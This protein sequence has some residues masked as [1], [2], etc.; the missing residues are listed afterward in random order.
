[1][2]TYTEAGKAYMEGLAKMVRK[3]LESPPGTCC[4]C[5]ADLPP[6]PKEAICPECGDIAWS[7]MQQHGCTLFDAIMVL[8]AGRQVVTID[9]EAWDEHRDGLKSWKLGPD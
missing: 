1:M 7:I 6:N 3:S 2:D 5:F 8:R 9:P 4:A